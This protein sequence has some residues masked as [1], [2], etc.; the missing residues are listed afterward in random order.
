MTLAPATHE[1]RAVRGVMYHWPRPERARMQN[2]DVRRNYQ[3]VDL[4]AHDH[5]QSWTVAA[6]IGP[7]SALNVL[8]ERLDHDLLFWKDDEGA[9]YRLIELG[10][11]RSWW[12]KRR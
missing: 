2:V 10:T 11:E 5:P 4:K 6:R 7:D 1:P 3:L 8:E 9:D 12:V